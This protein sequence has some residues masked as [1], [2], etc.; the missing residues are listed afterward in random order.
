[1]YDKMFYSLRKIVKSLLQLPWFQGY[2]SGWIPRGCHAVDRAVTC[3]HQPADSDNKPFKVSLFFGDAGGF[4]PATN[5]WQS[6][7]NFTAL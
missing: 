2:V 3:D 1:M 7:E 4:V 5:E 6:I